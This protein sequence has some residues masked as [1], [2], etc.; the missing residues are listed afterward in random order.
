[1]SWTLEDLQS[2]NASHLYDSIPFSAS[3]GSVWPMH[4]SGQ[5]ARL[6]GVNWAGRAQEGAYEAAQANNRVA[7]WQGLTAVAGST[8]LSA[9]A[10][11][12]EYAHGLIMSQIASAMNPVD[13]VSGQFVVTSGL[14]VQD[15]PG[16]TYPTKEMANSRQQAAQI[17]ADMIFYYLN[18][19]ID[20]LSFGAARIQAHTQELNSMEYAPAHKVV[21]G[22]TSPHVCSSDMGNGHT[23]IQLVD[24]KSAPLPQDP[25]IQNPHPDEPEKVVENKEKSRFR[26]IFDGV[27][28][29]VGGT[30][31]TIAGA[32]GVVGGGAGE[33]P[34]GGLST[35]AVIAGIGGIGAGIKTVEDGLDQLKHLGNG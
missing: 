16:K 35:T 27:E 33:L 18:Q 25:L 29:V 2:W 24:Y 28:D 5:L 8:T 12:V 23:Q 15:P 6:A 20:A 13:P 3:Q 1:M 14:K 34:S 22:H 19:F 32:A 26:Q 11:S 7:D 17:H 31:L 30:A 10:E 4:F 21:D 9:V